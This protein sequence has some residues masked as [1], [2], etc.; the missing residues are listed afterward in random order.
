MHALHWALSAWGR[1]TRAQFFKN[2]FSL[3][4]EYIAA[5]CQEVQGALG[6]LRWN[7]VVL[8]LCS[9]RAV[10]RLPAALLKHT[11]LAWQA[12]CCA[13][14]AARGMYR[15]LD[16]NFKSQSIIHLWLMLTNCEPFI[17]PSCSE[18]M[19][20]ILWTPPEAWQSLVFGRVCG[21]VGCL[22]GWLFGW[23]VVWQNS[24]PTP[25]SYLIGPII[26]ALLRRYLGGV[27]PL[28]VL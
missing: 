18:W 4:I 28:W 21:S 23:L 3:I 7:G 1:N 12:F 2:H 8:W 14:A 19:R 26:L 22:V 5:A 11:S 13:R 16:L 24:S 6:C 25:E 15:W 17:S 10:S 27:C 9:A 20:M